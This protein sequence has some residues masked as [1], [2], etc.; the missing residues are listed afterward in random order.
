LTGRFEKN[1]QKV[2][3]VPYYKTLSYLNK[4]ADAALLSKQEIG[5]HFEAD[6]VINLEINSMR[7]YDEG[8]YKQLFRG[9]AEILVTVYDVHREPGEGPAYEDVYRI[10]YP[11][12]GPLDA[13]GSS[14]LQ[15]RSAFM[16]RLARDLSRLFADYPTNEKFDMD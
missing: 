6:Y 10:Q 3:I 8:S 4:Q 5:K 13:S 16:S 9:N 7:F 14:V 12:H 2:K 11:S 15:F 1:H